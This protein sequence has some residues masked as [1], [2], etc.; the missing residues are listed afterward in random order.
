MKTLRLLLLVGLLAAFAF[1]VAPVRADCSSKDGYY[2]ASLDATIDPGTADFM[3]TTV[4]NAMAACA[5]HLVFVL[6]TFGGDGGS[7]DQMISSISSYQG[8]G[9]TVTTLIAPSGS[10]AFSAGS[11]IA[12]ASNK[13]VMVGG[14]I[15]GSATPIVSG[16]PVGEENTT[17]RK[18]IDGFTSYMQALTGE[19]QRNATA[20]G[21]MVS[22]GVSYT[23]TQALKEHVIDQRLNS[24]SLTD[25]LTAL[26]VPS[27]ASVNGEGIK[28]QLISVLS[29]PN[30]SSLM[31][32]VGVFAVLFDIYHPTIVLSIGGVILM[33]IALF[34]LGVFGA[35]ALSIILM[36]L[37]AAFIFLEVK[38]QH[39]I[40]ATIGVVVFAIGFLLVFQL[41][42]SPAQPSIAQ[43]PVGTFNAVPFSSYLLLAVIGAAGIIGSIY[44]MRIRREMQK[45][46]KANDPSRMIGKVGKMES[47]LKPG[48]QGVAM[49]GS[50]EWT[51]TSADALTKGTLVKVKE[52]S[53][54]RLL[55]EKTES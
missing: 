33:A 42:P 2:V 16:I 51:V 27:G 44:L 3:A 19:F 10:H 39:G 43:P 12:E 30:V 4:S 18:D 49:I 26:G 23:D 15:I 22:M 48:S 36:I 46:P 14:T 20:A 9:G 32:L 41:P 50:E 47:D 7:M 34:G 5:G 37:G 11:Y 53:G 55:V 28:S 21:L 6:N 38:T 35:S 29:D 52:V 8:W 17:L 54:N 40:S 13:I 1:Q 45:A 24:T 31:F 25:A